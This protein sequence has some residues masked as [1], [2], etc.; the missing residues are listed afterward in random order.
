M[1]TDDLLRAKKRADLRE[2]MTSARRKCSE[3]VRKYPG[4]DLTWELAMI[5]A[6]DAMEEVIDERD[7]L[8]VFKKFVHDRLDAA[9]VPTDPESPHKEHG[10]R[11]GGRLD[12]V[13]TFN[14]EAEA[15]IL[16]LRAAIADRGAS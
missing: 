7:K 13:L 16:R 9:G 3:T 1:T 4:A 8:A 11:I 6:I 15:E 5:E 12:V 2:K 14:S 10:C